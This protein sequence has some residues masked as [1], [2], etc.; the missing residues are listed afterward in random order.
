VDIILPVAGLG[1]RLR[2]HT[3]TK[4]KP[5]VSIAGKPILEHVLDRVLPLEP[6]RLVFITGYL[7]DQIEAWAR[8]RYPEIEL[9]F[10]EQPEM[11]GQTDAIVRTRHLV[12]GDALILFPDMLFEADFSVLRQT[13]ADAVMFTK[14]VEDPSALGIAVVEEG[15]ITKLIEKP[16][17]PISNLAVIGIYYVR[18]MP[19]LFSAIDEQMRRGISLKNEYFIADA[20]QLMIDAGARI[21][22]APVTEWEDCGSVEH[23]LATNA[24][25]LDRMAPASVARP[26]AVVVA[27]SIVHESAVLERCVVGPHASVG[28][29][30]AVRDA[31]LRDCVVEENA[32]IEN[33]VVSHALIGRRAKIGGTPTALNVGD[34]SWTT[35]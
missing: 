28:P 15:R 2:P 32:T 34:D 3:W 26:D 14:W 6:S 19:K 5:L 31:V 23:L 7:G 1:S 18:E 11:K 24:W 22:T 29:G 20:M 13:D 25:L 30:A 33:V 8:G 4:P 16:K 17:D 10:V 12:S 35:L 21:V 27:P 9:S